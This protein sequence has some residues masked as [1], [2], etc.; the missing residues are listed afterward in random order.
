MIELIDSK[1]A[2]YHRFMVD[3]NTRILEG[4]LNPDDI[5]GVISSLIGH[6][7]RAEV[8]YTLVL[9][10]DLTF[11]IYDS[12]DANKKV[13][14]FKSEERVKKFVNEHGSC[15][16][17]P[18]NRGVFFLFTKE[19]KNKEEFFVAYVD[20]DDGGRI[21][22]NERGRFGSGCFWGTSY[23]RYVVVPPNS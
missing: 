9:Q 23:P 22:M 7:K 12:V 17:M 14:A 6:K 5:M 16:R 2:Q 18:D 10:K 15:L 4:S 20:F 3:I 1:L 13:L 19:I 8:V 21:R 11:S